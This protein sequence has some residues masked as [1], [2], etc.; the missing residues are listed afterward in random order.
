[1][2]LLRKAIASSKVDATNSLAAC[3]CSSE[4]SAAITAGVCVASSCKAAM[5]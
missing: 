2:V 1:M 4:V 3:S 5:A